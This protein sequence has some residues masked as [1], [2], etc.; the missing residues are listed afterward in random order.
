MT[1][2]GPSRPLPTPEN[3]NVQAERVFGPAIAK[4]LDR[5]GNGAL[6]VKAADGK[7]FLAWLVDFLVFLLGVAVGVVVLATVDLKV[8]I[9]NGTIALCLIAILFLVPLLYGG[10]CYRNGRALGGVI[11]GI[12]L[13]RLADGG[14]IDGKAPW[15]TVRPTSSATST[16][17]A[18]SGPPCRST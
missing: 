2:P 14:R 3:A 6:Y 5:F 16:W 1:V 8:D 18:C 15:A 12:Q 11:V 10:L 7:L 4:R 17:A 13:V 9:D